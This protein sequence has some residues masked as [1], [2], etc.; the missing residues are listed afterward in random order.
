MREDIKEKILEWL[1]Q[2]DKDYNQGVELL[3]LATSAIT[4]NRFRRGNPALLLPHLVAFLRRIAGPSV[5]SSVKTTS[6]IPSVKSTASIPEP[7]RRA[8]DHLHSLWLRLVDFHKRLLDLGFDNSDEKKKARVALMADRAPFIEAFEQLY[9]LKEEFFAYPEGSRQ[10]PPDLIPLLDR[11][12]GKPTMA[13][14]KPIPS[15]KSIKSTPD[16]SS[17]SPL[18]LYKKRHALLMAITRRNNKLRFSQPTP[19]EQLNP[20]PDSPKRKAIESE[21]A[22]LQ[23]QLQEIDSLL[24]K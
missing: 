7:I 3:E 21:I 9:L 17:L 23:Q 12:D 6:P 4:A 19:A 22:T 11:L 1:N 18:E 14:D 5:T 15:I 13:T 20:M 8:K 10:L 2:N 16:F 24:N